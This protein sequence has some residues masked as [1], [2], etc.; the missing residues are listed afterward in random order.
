MSKLLKQSGHTGWMFVFFPVSLII[1]TS[2]GPKGSNTVP[3]IPLQCPEFIRMST[4]AT[5][6]TEL[7]PCHCSSWLF[8][9]TSFHLLLCY[10]ECACAPHPR[11]LGPHVSGSGHTCFL[12]APPVTSVVSRLHLTLLPRL[13][14]SPFKNKKRKKREQKVHAHQRV[15]LLSQHLDS[16]ILIYFEF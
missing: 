3:P 4:L 1:I 6:L 14:Y 9:L 2:S 11:Q 10:S 15:V 5:N 7:P 16:S 13:H 12:S 8:A